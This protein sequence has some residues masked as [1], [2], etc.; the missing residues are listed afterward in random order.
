[1]SPIYKTKQPCPY[2]GR[3]FRTKSED[4][5]QALVFTCICGS[6]VTLEFD[7]TDEGNQ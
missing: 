3:V 5:A 4:V 7:L 6:D 1:M 2:C